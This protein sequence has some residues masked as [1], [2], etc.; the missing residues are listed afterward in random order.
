MPLFDGPS[1]FPRGAPAKGFR[2]CTIAGFRRNR[3][4]ERFQ[5]EAVV[6][7]AGVVGLAVARALAQA[8]HETLILEKNAELGAETSSRSSEVIHAGLYPDYPPGSLKARLCVEGRERLYAFAAGHG[9]ACRRIGKW[10]VATTPD[11][12]AMLAAIQAAAQRHGV[13]DL[14][15]LPAATVKAEEPALRFTEVLASPS[16]GIIDSHAYMLAL[17]GDAESSGARLVRK[18]AVMAVARAEGG[19]RLT[20]DNGGEAHVLHARLVVNSAGLW[21]NR[22]AARIAGL[23]ARFIPTLHL[24]KGNY[25]AYQGAVPFRRLIYPVPE[26]G[27]LGVHLT[28]DL[29]GGGRLG[30][31]VEWLEHDDPARIDYAPPPGIAQDFAARARSWWPDL[32]AARLTPAYSGVRPKLHPKGTAMVDFRIDGPQVHG[33]AGL[34][35]LFGI[36]SPGL[37]ASLAIARHVVELLDHA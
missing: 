12:T 23:E 25:A 32:E 8:G 1:G 18:A 9:V 4:M 31:D 22:L 2:V 5:S 19:W 10:L 16:T 30:P 14:A 37:T 28:L 34:V 6:I 35:N 33:L 3:R 7:G 29:A 27:G 36:E 26:P 20:V 13:T 15:P 21:A 11:Q 17:L 24:A